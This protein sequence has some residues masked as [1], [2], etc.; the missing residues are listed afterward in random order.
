MTEILNIIW[1]D[2]TSSPYICALGAVIFFSILFRDS[3]AKYLDLL[4]VS[5]KG[6]KNKY[7]KKD[8]ERHPIFLDL[9]YWLTAG[10]SILQINTCLGKELIMKDLLL[11]KYELIKNKLNKAI[12]EEITDATEVE[13]LLAIFTRLMVEYNKEQILRWKAANIPDLFIKKYLAVQVKNIDLLKGSARIVFSKNII[14]PKFNRV[15]LL[16][17][18]LR[19]YLATTYTN[20]VATILSMN[21]DLN[22]LEY[23]GVKIEEYHSKKVRK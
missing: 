18:I 3:I 12:K 10:V 6:N 17:S 9:E 13:D 11:I 20:A 22:G 23:R 8:L 1:K 4:M 21:G 14:S 2:M 16:L 15:Y 5:R 19:N 7:S